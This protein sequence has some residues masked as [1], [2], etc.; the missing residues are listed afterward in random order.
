MPVRLQRAWDFFVGTYSMS[1]L[2]RQKEIQDMNYIYMVPD[3]DGWEE[4]KRKINF[5]PPTNIT[6]YEKHLLLS[7]IKFLISALKATSLTC[8]P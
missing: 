8:L 6:L 4:A 2:S 1:F 3:T 7:G 5:P